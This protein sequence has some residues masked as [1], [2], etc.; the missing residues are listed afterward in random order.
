MRA[1]ITT[2]FVFALSLLSVATAQDPTD[3]AKLKQ[4]NE[5]LQAK[6]EAANLKIEKLE[7]QLAEQLKA[8]K[9]ATEK[10]VS[11]RKLSLSDRIPAGTAILGNYQFTKT[12]GEAG[13]VTLTI[14]ER[15]GNKV[16]GTY[17]PKALNAAEAYLGWSFEGVIAGNKLTAKSV[18]KAA[19]RTLTVNMKGDTLEG[20]V[21]LLEQQE[22]AS[23]AFSFQ[24]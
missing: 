12:G 5:L 20:S 1:M 21:V 7:N 2:F 4:Q 14:T 6:L 22:T 10:E 15:D 16:K 11:K 3:V 8:N 24:K 19:K 9:L 18:G 17:V 23:V 13:T